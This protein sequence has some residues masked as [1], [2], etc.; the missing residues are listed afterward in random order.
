MI[1]FAI[2]QA[3]VIVVLALKGKA[4]ALGGIAGLVNITALFLKHTHGYFDGYF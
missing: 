3:L 4:L 2:Y 1:D